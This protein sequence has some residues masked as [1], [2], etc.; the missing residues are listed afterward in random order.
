MDFLDGKI[1]AVSGYGM[2][3][4]EMKA[5]ETSGLSRQEQLERA[6]FS[7]ILYEMSPV[8]PP[9]GIVVATG[10]SY[11]WPEG[12]FTDLTIDSDGVFYGT[13]RVPPGGGDGNTDAAYYLSTFELGN[14]DM[15]RV[16][17]AGTL[18][19]EFTTP[20]NID[21]IYLGFLWGN[22]TAEKNIGS[23]ILHQGGGGI[24]YD[25]DNFRR[26]PNGSVITAGEAIGFVDSRGGDG[27][28]NHMYSAVHVLNRMENPY[29][30]NLIN[31]L[32]IG[33]VG[34]EDEQLDDYW[35]HGFMVDYDNNSMEHAQFLGHPTGNITI[36]GTLYGYSAVGNDT[37]PNEEEESDN[38]DG[39]D[40]WHDWYGISLE[41]G[42]TIIL[43]GNL[44]FAAA[45]IYDF[46][47]HLMASY[48]YRTE[49]DNGL[50]GYGEQSPEVFT[51]PMAGVYY[52]AVLTEGRDGT[53]Y[54]LNIENVNKAVLG[55]INIV[56]NY[57]HI[58]NDEWYA[59]FN[60]VPGDPDRGNVVVENGG[61]LGGLSVTGLAVDL[62]TVARGGGDIV[63]WKAGTV[64]VIAGVSGEN[65]EVHLYQPCWIF[66]EGNIGS[67]AVT[68]EGGGLIATIVA[69]HSD[70]VFNNNAFIQNIYIEGDSMPRRGAYGTTI[71]ASGSIGVITC[72]GTLRPLASRSITTMPARPE[73]STS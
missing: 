52:I 28:E 58:H 33:P 29:Y 34:L 41:A 12:R 51:A 30:S 36:T 62:I 37:R 39:D 44:G 35:I 27:G 73:R 3:R 14:V 42:Q 49:D 15:G 55:G 1:Y 60:S 69:G 68:D 38:P 17:I 54:S 21:V 65:E 71:R 43:S 31:E 10:S 59:I 5:L 23:V 67:V 9:S 70:G 25:D 20:A 16:F 19:G 18:A 4:E 45:R 40:Y 64:G 22:I 13:D 56:G 6:F 2:G 32:E 26:P 63:A 53:T 50:G 7:H 46:S 48:G 66:S 8:V 24:W 11:L 47:G 72:R 57:G 61:S